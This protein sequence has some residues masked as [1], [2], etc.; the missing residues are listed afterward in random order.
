M[1]VLPSALRCLE[2]NLHKTKID[3]SSLREL[4]GVRVSDVRVLRNPLEPA[5]HLSLFPPSMVGLDLIFG[6]TLRFPLENLNL[7]ALTA[8]GNLTLRWDFDFLRS[9]TIEE[10]LGSLSDFISSFPSLQ[11]VELYLSP[12]VLDES[13]EDYFARF[14]EDILALGERHLS[15][16]IRVYGCFR[17]KVEKHG[18][19]SYMKSKKVKL[20][21]FN[22]KS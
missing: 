10:G 4:T 20:W 18:S 6:H 11:V 17:K 5:S 14:R 19:R 9:Q 7:K 2:A 13:N 1:K 12:E 15:L 22:P 3:L 8:C 16:E 21:T